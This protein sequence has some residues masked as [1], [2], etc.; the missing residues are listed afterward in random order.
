MKKILTF[1]FRYIKKH[2]I[3]YVSYIVLSLIVGLISI[4]IP[5]IVGQ[6]I[7]VLAGKK[8]GFS[9]KNLV[10]FFM[11]F[12]IMRMI[13][14]FICSHIF[15]KL[16][17]NT[18]YYSN[19]EVI[20]RLYKTSYINV[21]NEDPAALHQIINND[22]NAITI[23]TISFFRDILVNIVSIIFITDIIVKQSVELSILFI[24]LV[25][26]YI[27]LYL[28]FRKPLYNQSLKVKNNQVLFFGKL[29]NIVANLKSIKING[30]V[31]RVINNQ[32]Y[33]F[34]D[35]QKSIQEQLKIS[36]AYDFCAN[37]I[38]LAS[39]VSLFL[40]GGKL[41]IS[42]NMN[43]GIFV[44]L[45]NY[46]SSLLS[47]TNYFLN[48][49]EQFQ[50]IKTSY[51]RLMKYFNL[52][53]S[54]YGDKELKNINSIEFNEV[55]FSYPG[56]RELFRISKRFEKGKI[57]WIKGDNGSG[58]STFIHLL[59]GL[60]EM[61]Y[62]G[63]IF[64]ND[65]EINEIDPV[66][67]A[68]NNIT[69]V[70]QRPYILSDT[71]RENILCKCNNLDIDEN[72]RLVKYILSK[73]DICNMFDKLPQGMDTEFNALTDNM[74]GG[75]RQKIALARL[76]LSTADIWILDEPTSAL[77]RSSKNSFYKVLEE[78]KE[79]H[80]TFIISHENIECYDEI[81]NF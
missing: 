22:C 78:N 4:S 23:F 66:G 64:I 24:V 31:D 18:G 33:V 56:S 28:V 74:S 62:E 67:L 51:D 80:I 63:D 30:F 2:W 71:F 49:G 39:Q 41:V 26:L 14:T 47:S 8:T 37:L 17:S 6:I 81:L 53:Q 54:I 48:L 45:S 12:S 34:N 79:Y 61:D 19:I 52:P 38:S 36:N 11:F 69:V 20:Q 13:I 75:E 15:L 21:G 32:N 77:D 25:I 68:V 29:Y 40:Y 43:I 16:Q 58:K 7:D 9:I 60:F 5:W 50:N 73:L 10:I 46:F 35:Y 65:I 3:L 1:G 27:V 44:I 72:S 76:F 57:Y 59:T 70:E 55:S 42:G